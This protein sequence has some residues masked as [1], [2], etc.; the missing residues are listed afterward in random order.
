MTL[1]MPRDNSRPRGTNDKR[2]RSDSTPWLP[3]VEQT[4][5]DASFHSPSKSATRPPEG[6]GDREPDRSSYRQTVVA[7]ERNVFLLRAR[8]GGKTHGVQ[9]Q[10]GRHDTFR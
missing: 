1:T 8:K 2:W 9:R 5:G 3:Q 10:E 6:H 4:N 7:T